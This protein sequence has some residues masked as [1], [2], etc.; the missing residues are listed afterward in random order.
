MMNDGDSGSSERRLEMRRNFR[1]VNRSCRLALVSLQA[2]HHTNIR[3]LHVFLWGKII[4]FHYF[5]SLILVE[6]IGAIIPRG[7]LIVLLEYQNRLIL[8][9]RRIIQEI[10]MKQPFFGCN[11]SLFSILFPF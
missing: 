2:L 9:V 6:T 5:F 8:V 1:R 4:F 10:W 7:A 3:F 11:F